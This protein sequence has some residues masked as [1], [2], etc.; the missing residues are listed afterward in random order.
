MSMSDVGGLLSV[1]ATD[2]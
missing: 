1:R 2:L